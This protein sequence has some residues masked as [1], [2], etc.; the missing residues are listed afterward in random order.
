MRDFK[1]GMDFGIGYD[2]LKAKTRGSAVTS[3]VPREVSGAGGPIIFFSIQKINS[4]EALQN[5]LDINTS[6]SASL[7]FIEG[8]GSFNFST[9]VKFH[10]YSEYLVAKV[11]VLNPL[12]MIQNVKLTPDAATLLQR[13]ESDLFYRTYGDYFVQGIKTGGAYYAVLEF[14]SNSSTAQQGLSAS[15]DIGAFNIF[16]GEAAFS[17]S[18]R[19][20]T[21]GTRI[22]IYSFQVGGT[23][24]TQPTNIDGIIQKTSN[25][26]NQIASSGV[27]FE[28]LIQDYNTLSLPRPPNFVDIENAKF[29]LLQFFRQ[30]NKLL[31]ILNDIDYIQEHQDQFEGVENFNFAESTSKAQGWLDEITNRASK[32]ALT[33]SVQ[34]CKFE[35]PPMEPIIL[36][37]RKAMD[38]TSHHF[39][40]VS[41]IKI[42]SLKRFNNEDKVL[43][44]LYNM[45]QTGTDGLPN[46]EVY[47]YVWKENPAH[48]DIEAIVG[49]LKHQNNTVTVEIGKLTYLGLKIETPNKIFII[50]NTPIEQVGPGFVVFDMT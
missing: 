17:E 2:F 16:K 19:A 35:L 11:V 14:T 26:P 49:I 18:L 38:M 1:D 43:T 37:K 40:V 44:P 4:M 10:H 5:A 39:D 48:Q 21:G 42:T 46:W 36:P 29:V 20:L 23:D 28:A 41:R 8:S 34:D 30:R 32:C 33:N 50:P 6:F 9:G 47:H 22:K 15:L 27:S 12:R 3:D 24:V 45:T 25:F 7:E 31:T 13:G